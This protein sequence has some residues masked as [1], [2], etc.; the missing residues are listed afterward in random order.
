MNHRRYQPKESR[1]QQMLLPARIDE[2]VG[3]NH[4]VRAIDAYADTLDLGELGF[5]HTEYGTQA[6]QPPYDPRV[7]VKI[8]LYGYTNSIR[9]SRRLS[10]ECRRNMEMIWLAQ[11]AH[12]S[13]ATVASFRR[14]NAKALREVNRDFVKLCGE[15]ELFGGEQ[16]AVDG[17]FI[18]ADANKTTIHT[19]DHLEG[20]L[21]EIEKKVEEYQQ[22]LERADTG[23]GE[24]WKTEDEGLGAKLEKIEQR[25]KEKQALRE[26]LERSGDTQISTVDEDARLMT[27]RGNTIPGYN[28]QIAV[29]S[30]NNLVVSADVSQDGND[31]KQLAPM[32]SE[33]KE[34]LGA[35]ELEA[36]ADAG[37]CSGAQIMECEQNDVTVYAPIIERSGKKDRIGK[38]KFRYDADSDSYRC[39]GGKELLRG[40]KV[41]R[42]GRNYIRYRSLKADCDGCP[43][44]DMCLGEK[45]RTREVLRWEN[46]DVMER[47]ALRMKGAGEKMRKRGSMVE[48]PFGTIKNR[49]GSCGFLMRGI[50]R[51]RGEFS[52]M[53]FAYNFTRVLNIVG[54]EGFMEYCARRRVKYAEVA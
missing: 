42:S 48:H 4:P 18:K 50:E 9:S 1:G 2:Y 16:V 6:G 51:C 24:E 7:L 15:L 37:Y 20:E 27:K 8:Y 43:L 47:H 30:K 23:E 3:E 44:R 40:A 31:M 35:E 39:P 17:T 11:G 28:A 46:E 36:L 52:L 49:N 5:S 45:A 41:K 38:D 12:P 54:V 25:Q 33:A 34:A 26:E 13:H 29:D 14:D 19:K 53:V 10:A 22:A 21:E 32:V